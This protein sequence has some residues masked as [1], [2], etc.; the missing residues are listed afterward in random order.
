MREIGGDPRHHR[1]D[2]ADAQRRGEDQERNDV[3][4]AVHVD[5]PAQHLRADEAHAQHHQGADQDGRLRAAVGKSEA[6]HHRAD[7]LAEIERRRMHRGGGAARG[8]RQVGDVDLDAGVQQVEAEP[9]GAEDQHLDLPGK[10]QRQQREAAGGD[11]AA[12]HHQMPLRH[13][14]HQIRHRQRIEDAAGGKAGD[15]QAGD[16]GAG[17]ADGAQQD[18]DVGKQ[19][20]D[21]D[22][23]EE[24][25]AEADFRARIGEHAAEVGDHRGAA[26][27]RRLRQCGVAERPERQQRD[28]RPRSCRGSRT[29]RASRTG[30]RSRRRPKRRA[31]W[32]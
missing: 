12:D 10:M 7:R 24:H 14:P 30:R 2:G 19:A 29:R 25:R 5:P 13:R 21:E 20:L 3:E 23:F 16:R 6:V 17:H 11:G 1:V 26:E 4:R 9:E 32:R 28:Q 22:R 27:R 18:R 31:H 8:L 15:Q